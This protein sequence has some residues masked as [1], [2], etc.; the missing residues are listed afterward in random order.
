MRDVKVDYLSWVMASLTASYGYSAA[1]GQ[2]SM[3]STN[4]VISTVLLGP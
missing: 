2:L 3:A 4:S 1:D